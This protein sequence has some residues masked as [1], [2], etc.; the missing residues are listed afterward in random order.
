VKVS[1]LDDGFD[2]LRTL[3]CWEKLA[4]HDVSGAP[5]NVVNPEVRARARART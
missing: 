4:A 3:R 5:T 2:T 1:V